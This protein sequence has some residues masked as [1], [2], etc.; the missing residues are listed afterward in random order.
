[1]RE[2]SPYLFFVLTVI[3]FFLNFLGLMK[4]IPLFITLPLLFISLYMTIFS[5]FHR[6]TFRG[7][8]Y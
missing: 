7:R 5:F 2:L 6:R 3:A 4:L 8:M 1:M